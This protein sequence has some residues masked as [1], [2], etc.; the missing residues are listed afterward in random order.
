MEATENQPEI[1]S[2]IGMVSQYLDTQKPWIESQQGVDGNNDWHEP[3]I[4]LD[5]LARL[6]RMSALHESAMDF[7]ARL[8]TMGYRPH[9]TNK[10]YVEPLKAG[11]STALVKKYWEKIYAFYSFF[12]INDLYAFMHDFFT[13]GNGYLEK[14]SNKGRGK[15]AGLRR[16]NARL[17]RILKKDKGYAIVI[18]DEVKKSYKFDQLIHKLQPC[19]ESDYYGLPA[20][21]GAIN[22]IILSDAARVQRIQFYDNNGYLGGLIVSNLAV[23]DVDKDGVSETETKIVDDINQPVITVQPFYKITSNK[24][25]TTSD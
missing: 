10:N 21:T 12:P 14:I 16:R 20:Y 13:F 22:D 2:P 5:F 3:P 23:D 11:A 25:A 15:T 4:Q 24:P 1:P 19:S 17:M 7:K 6:S 8:V 18:D 9:R